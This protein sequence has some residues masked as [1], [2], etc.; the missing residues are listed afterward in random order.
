MG[1]DRDFF[2]LD[3]P[4]LSEESKIFCEGPIVERE[5]MEVLKDMKLN[6]SPGNDGLTV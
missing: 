2:P 4:K 1:Q 5:C 6:K 3:L